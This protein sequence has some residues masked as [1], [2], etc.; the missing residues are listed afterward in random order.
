MHRL[1]RHGALHVA[2]RE[3]G[4]PR[5]QAVTSRG[6]PVVKDARPV[7]AP[8]PVP[9]GDHPAFASPPIQIL[10]PGREEGIPCP[11]SRCFDEPASEG[12]PFTRA[13][14]EHGGHRR[15]EAP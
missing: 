5:G 13:R 11:P 8:S 7:A 4:A 2:L 14:A 10:G 9:R 12:C 15:G 1:D 6:Q 3:G